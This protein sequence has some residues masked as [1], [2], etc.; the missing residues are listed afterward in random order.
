MRKLKLEALQVESFETTGTAG[1]SRGT[2]AG[3]AA[4]A[5]DAKLN[6]DTE[7]SYCTECIES[8]D[9]PCGPTPYGP[10]C[11]YTEEFDCTFFNC[12]WVSPS[13]CC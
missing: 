13:D 8:V 11:G 10:E 3:N 1:T 6:D 7:V 12:S 9:L 4:P 5:P 2:V